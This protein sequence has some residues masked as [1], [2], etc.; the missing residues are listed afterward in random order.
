MPAVWHLL[1]E[2]EYVS[3]DADIRRAVRDAFSLHKARA[4]GEARA[5]ADRVIPLLVAELETD[6]LSLELRV[7]AAEW[8]HD[9]SYLGSRVR[10]LAVELAKRVAAKYGWSNGIDPSE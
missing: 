5:L 6:N 3:P 9:P 1:G 2:D 4:S 10:D 7:L 8:I